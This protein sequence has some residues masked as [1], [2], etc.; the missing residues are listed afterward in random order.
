MTTPRIFIDGDQGTTGLQIHDRLRKRTDIIVQTLANED[1]KDTLKRAEALNH[2]DVA[3]LCL[4][5][6]A[7]RDAVAMLENPNVRVIDASSAHRLESNWVYGFPEMETAQTNKIRQAN[8]VT[9]PGCYPTGA[10]GLLHPLIQAGLLP[11]DYPLAIHAIS[12]YSGGGRAAVEL[13]EG[14]HS[15]QAPALQMYGLALK[16]KHVPEI[17]RYAGL[18]EPPV[19]V[20]AYAAYRQG[21]VLSVPLQQ[22]LLPHDSDA[23]TLHAC[24][25]QHYALTPHVQVLPLMTSASLERLDPQ[26]L[27]GTNTMQLAVF[28]NPE[29]GQI[30]LT[31]I[32]DNLGKGAAGAAVQNL[33]IMLSA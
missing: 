9:N 24:L 23:S 19:F 25:A 7:A 10:I 8:R 5:D 22:R 15:T 6:A 14:T 21:I 29:Y 1:R 33:D 18:S 2:C 16:H 32:F 27:N 31:A 3:I 12:G 4:P 13:H 30:L 26:Q 11:Q 20:P 17:Q 28:S